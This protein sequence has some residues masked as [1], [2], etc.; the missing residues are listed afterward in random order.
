MSILGRSLLCCLCVAAVLSYSL[1]PAPS[2]TAQSSAADVVLRPGRIATVAGGWSVVADSVGGRRR[3]GPP[4][5]RGRRQAGAAA[6]EPRALFRG[7]VRRGGRTSPIGSGCAAAAQS[8][9]WAQ[10]LGVR[11]V[12]QLGRRRRRGALRIGT[13]SALEVNLEEC[14]GCGLP[15]WGWQDN[16][17][18][19][20]VLGPE[21]DLRAPPG[22]SACG[23]RRARTASTIDQIVLSPQRYLTS[24]PGCAKNDTPSFRRTVP[25]TA[26]GGAAAPTCSRCPRLA[27]SSCGPRANRRAPRSAHRLARRERSAAAAG[28]CPRSTSGLGY[29]YYHHEVTVTGLSPGDVVQLRREA[30]WT[31]R[32]LRDVPHRAADRHRDR[33]RSSC[34][35]TAGRDR[36]SSGSSPR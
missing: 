22:P 4:S 11:A 16:G 13:T 17:W 33:S 10:R 18:G 1:A 15:A 31:R 6:R 3:R 21:V 24:A 35:A 9:Y 5:E 2:V 23:C 28:W 32:R 30:R 27:S 25:A 36:P 8:D 29:D 7:V 19:V 14:S 20:G 26:D 34:S 12:H